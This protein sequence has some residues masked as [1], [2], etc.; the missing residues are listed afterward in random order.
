MDIKRD[1]L[2]NWG[3]VPCN[4]VSDVATKIKSCEATLSIWNKVDFRHVQTD[5]RKEKCELGGL[6]KR[7]GSGNMVAAIDICRSEL[8]DLKD[9]EG[10][11]WKQRS[12][13]TWLKDGDHNIRFYHCL[14]NTRKRRNTII[15]I[16]DDNG[17]IYTENANIGKA[18]TYYLTDLFTSTSNGDSSAV[19]DTITCSISFDERVLLET[20]FPRADV[21]VRLD[22]MFLEKAPSSN[23]MTVAFYKK[24]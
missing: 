24:H 7:A 3:K 11:L 1:N 8:R 12:R 13:A 21:K 15:E 18:F 6:L 22:T 23:G 16:H 19:L 20:P 2:C 9:K 14:A 4:S 5:I 10:E 17:D